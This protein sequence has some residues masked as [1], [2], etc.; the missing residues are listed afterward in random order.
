MAAEF[1]RDQ[2]FRVWKATLAVER[3]SPSSS[4][5]FYPSVPQPIYF[6]N[7]SGAIIPPYSMMQV[8]GCIEEETGGQ[9][10]I[11]VRKPIYTTSTCRC[12]LL[13]NGAEEIE[14]GGFGTAQFGPVF[15]VKTDGTA[16]DPGDRLGPENASW[17]ATYGA[18]Y[19]VL[20]ND[21]IE[22]DVVRVMFDVSTMRAQTISPLVSGTPGN[23]KAY[24][25]N[26]TL[27]AKEYV[28]E[29]D[30][31]TIAGT[32]NILLFVQYGRFFA[33]KYC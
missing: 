29:T 11:T 26:G 17:Q 6:R 21:D 33:L 1:S 27:T 10:Y 30:G 20:G 15:R 16:Y 32:T 8:I 5:E 4:D 12:P 14:V 2:K 9:N 31:T 7:D 23:V 19:T 24:D 18:M 3:M 22:E 13:F 25:A 28:A